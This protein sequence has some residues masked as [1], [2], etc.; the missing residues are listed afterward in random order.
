MGKTWKNAIDWWH[1]ASWL[2]NNAVMMVMVPSVEPSSEFVR[3][4]FF[5]TITDG[6]CLVPINDRRLFQN[7]PDLVEG[8]QE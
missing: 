2:P 1:D 3:C 6:Y 7:I 5:W 4:M 8:N